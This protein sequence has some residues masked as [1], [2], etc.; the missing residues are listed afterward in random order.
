VAETQEDPVI[1]RFEELIAELQNI[2]LDIYSNY[3][4]VDD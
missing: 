1:E 4:R 2:F 3:R